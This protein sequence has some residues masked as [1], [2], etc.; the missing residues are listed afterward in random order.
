MWVICK[1]K[2]T[3]IKISDVGGGNG[4]LFFSSKKN[5]PGINWNWTVFES[6]AVALAYAQ[7]EEESGIKWQSSNIQIKKNSEVALFSCT[8]QYLKSPLKELKKY[9]LHHKYLI[10]TRVPFINEDS[11]IITRQTFPDGENIR[12]RILRGRLGFF[13]RKN[14]L[15][16]F[17]K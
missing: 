2:Y 7:F 16:K 14:S 5:I 6:D 1:N 4:Y 9:A 15:L 12:I 11:H 17:V 3:D 13:Q 8:L 10:I